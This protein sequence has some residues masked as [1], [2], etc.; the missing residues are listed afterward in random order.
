MIPTDPQAR[1]A[2]GITPIKTQREEDSITE[3]ESLGNSIPE[4]GE[5]ESR[6]NIQNIKI[7]Q[8]AKQG[9]KQPK[10]KNK[11]RLRVQERE[12]E[13]PNKYSLKYSAPSAIRKMQIKTLSSI[14]PQSG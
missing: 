10:R 1:T 11:N 2:A 3:E 12:R 14:S 6:T 7:T 4:P 5:V 9:N 8:K 13:K